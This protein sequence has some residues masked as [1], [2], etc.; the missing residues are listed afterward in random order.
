MIEIDSILSNTMISAYGK[1][2]QWLRAGKFLDMMEGSSA[3][4]DIVTYSAAVRACEEHDQWEQAL[5]ILGVAR[6]RDLDAVAL[7]LGVLDLCSFHGQLGGLFE[8]TLLRQVFSPVLLCLRLL[9]F[10]PASLDVLPGLGAADIASTNRL[11]AA[12]LVFLNDGAL[13]RQFS[14]EGTLTW[15]AL[16]HFEMYCDRASWMALPRLKAFQRLCLLGDVDVLEGHRAKRR[17]TAQVAHVFSDH[18]SHSFHEVLGRSAGQSAPTDTKWNERRWLIPVLR[19]K[20]GLR[21]LEEEENACHAE[22]QALL[23]VLEPLLSPSTNQRRSGASRS[24]TSSRR[25]T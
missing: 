10:H 12:N 6:N 1:G 23:A 17:I 19:G 15:R 25:P 4:K 2:G 3:Q 21:C 8:Q 5:S 11:Q 16:Q 7:E 14:L 18:S 13:A 9:H 22:R 24:W 20:V